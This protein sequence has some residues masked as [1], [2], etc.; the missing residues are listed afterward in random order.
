MSM[1]IRAFI[2]FFFS[3][4]MV[5]A[6]M[7]AHEMYGWICKGSITGTTL[8]CLESLSLSLEF[9]ILFSLFNGGFNIFFDDFLFFL[10]SDA[11]ILQ[12]TDK[13]LLDCSEIHIFIL[14]YDV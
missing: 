3:Q 1:I 12:F 9:L 13:K 11:I 8:I 4:A 14:R 10:D 5:M 2:A 7:T 6:R